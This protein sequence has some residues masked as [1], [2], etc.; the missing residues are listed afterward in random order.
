MACSELF[1]A[2]CKAHKGKVPNNSWLW[3]QNRFGIPFW[4][5]GEFTTRFS[6]DFSGDWLMFT[7]STIWILTH[8]HVK[9]RHAAQPKTYAIRESDRVFLPLTALATQHST[10]HEVLGACHLCQL[11][12]AFCSLGAWCLIRVSSASCQI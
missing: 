9:M 3:S 12:G 7:G 1:K 11:L 2:R 4:W 5:V 6:R 8:G 10:W